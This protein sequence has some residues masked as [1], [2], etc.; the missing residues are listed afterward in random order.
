MN[1]VKQKLKGVSGVMWACLIMVVLLMIFVPNYSQLRNFDNILKNTAIL[2]IVSIGMTMSILGEEI[3]LSI[4][5]VM[6]AAAMIS[7][8]YIKQ[9]ENPSGLQLLVG[10]LI[11]MLVGAVFGF[12]NGLLIGKFKFNFWLVTFATMSMGYGISEAVTNGQILAGY[13]KKFRNITGGTLAGG[14]SNLVII[15]V[16]VTVIMYL[17]L[18]KTRFGM[19]VYAVG[20]SE[21]CAAQSGIKVAWVR[22][23]IYLFSG[24]LAGFGGVL[25]ISKANSASAS[26]ANGYEFDAIAA[27][28]IG[29]TPFEGGKGGLI[30]TVIGA[31][32]IQAFKSGLQL[33]GV[34]TYWQQTL[35]G[36]FI[37][38]VIVFDVISE[39]RKTTKKLRRVYRS[40]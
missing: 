40:E 25:L 35:I 26:V 6:S 32:I 1:V 17:V 10:F 15:A 13:S 4:G 33:I 19:H 23:R 24:I 8:I 30:G 22:M 39:N 18:L 27:V 34:S 21:Q 20:D 5:G 36:I 14:I 2:V 29:G 9:F 3:D 31:L 16:I 11:G 7:A 28:I 38:L 37:L 12:V